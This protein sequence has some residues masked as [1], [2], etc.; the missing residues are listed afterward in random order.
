MYHNQ[1]QFYILNSDLLDDLY[2]IPKK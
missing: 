1:I 2:L